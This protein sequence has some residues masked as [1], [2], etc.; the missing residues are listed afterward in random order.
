MISLSLL[1]QEPDPVEA[2]DI[3]E[4]RINIQNQGGKQVGDYIVELEPKY[5]FKAVYGEDL[6]KEV[7]LGGFFRK[8]RSQVI[9]FR[10]KVDS[11]AKSGTYSL[12]IIHYKDGEKSKVKHQKDLKIVI[13][14]TTSAEVISINTEKIVPGKKTLLE[15]IIKNV[16]KSPLRNA[17]FS[18][19]SKDDAILT[20]GSGN[21][22]H[23][24]EIKIGEEK[25]V[26][27]WAL[28][29]VN[30]KPGL[31]K[32]AMT[33]QY[34]YRS[35]NYSNF[36]DAESNDKE[37][38]ISKAGIYIGGGTEFDIT[39]D[40]ISSN[41]QYVFYLSNNG[42]SKASSLVVAIPE[43]DNWQ[44][45]GKKSAVIGNLIEGDYGIVEFD[46]TK[47]SMDNLPITLEITY[48]GT[49]GSRET[50][51]KEVV[52]NANNQTFNEISLTDDSGNN[53]NK[54]ILN[55]VN[56]IIVLGLIYLIYRWKKK[57]GKK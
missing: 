12:P 10:L 51:L 40:K 52:I 23:I 38:I 37:T 45:N 35:Q 30:A 32:I 18:W 47:N 20:V 50:L 5:P 56:V 16:G 34:D 25:L 13:T 28:T 54:S 29:D 46:L 7:N 8:D 31:Y 43:Q 4:L 3:V 22:R 26:S 36:S 9:K 6:I 41:G 53:K 33:L 24:D 19:E 39:F 27:F 1:N 11:D 2:G 17:V 14:S 57:K 42:N 21:V 44:V 55:A 15:F 48:T 49:D